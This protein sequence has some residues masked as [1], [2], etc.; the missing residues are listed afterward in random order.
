MFNISDYFKKFTKIEGNSI[1][2]KDAIMIALYNNC[3]IDKVKFE[4]KKD[5]LYVQGTPMIKSM[6]YTKKAS[7]IAS[8]KENLPGSRVS[9]IR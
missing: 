2:Q 4:L 8:I 9:D 7:I 6:I 3:G 1:I 5:I